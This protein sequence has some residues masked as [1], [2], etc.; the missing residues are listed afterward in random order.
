[1]AIIFVV[2]AIVIVVLIVL[3]LVIKFCWLGK[4]KFDTKEK[5]QV[6]NEG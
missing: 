6:F 3:G 4:R 5:F 2:A 1:M